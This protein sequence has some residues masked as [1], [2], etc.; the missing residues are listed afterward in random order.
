MSPRQPAKPATHKVNVPS[1]SGDAITVRY[2]GREPVTYPVTDG[3]VEVADADLSTFL[4]LDEGFT[5]P[6]GTPSGSTQE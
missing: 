1:T 6:G 4:A 5:A 3:T 2:A